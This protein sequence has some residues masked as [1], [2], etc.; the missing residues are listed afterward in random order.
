MLSGNFD[1]DT[2]ADLRADLDM[3]GV[4]LLVNI[5]GDDHYLISLLCYRCAIC[6]IYTARSCAAVL[7]QPILLCHILHWYVSPLYDTYSHASASLVCQCVLY[8]N[9][10]L[11][12]SS[13]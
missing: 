2:I 13:L 3:T 1:V 5:A 6:S 7:H 4:T 10:P 9:I 8:S 12:V 11:L